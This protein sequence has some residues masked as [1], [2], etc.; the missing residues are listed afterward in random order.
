MQGQYEHIL[1][2]KNWHLSSR[3]HQCLGVCEGMLAALSHMPLLPEHYKELMSVSLVKGAQATTAIEGNTLSDS[4]INL[5]AQGEKLAPSKEYQAIEV[6][7]IL[8]AFWEILTGMMIGEGV[9]RVTPRLI[10]DLHIKVGKDLGEHFDAIPGRFREDRRIVGPYRTP[11]PQDVESLVD[12]LCDWLREEFRYK[13]GEQCYSDAIVQAIVAHIYLEWIHPFGDG[14]GRTGRLLEFYIL[15]RAGVPNI[16]LHTLSNFYN[17]TRNE[18]YRH[19]HN[20]NTTRDLTNLISYAIQ[21]FK[22]GLEATLKTVQDAQLT[23][24]WERLIYDR[25]ASYPYR[26]KLMFQRQRM[27]AL[28]FPKD[29]VLSVDEIFLLTPEIARQYAILTPRTMQRDLKVLEDLRILKK[30]DGLYQADLAQLT[31]NYPLRRN[32]GVKNESWYL[33]VR[34][35]LVPDGTRP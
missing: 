17:S 24:T 13:D 14:N 23:L 25:F 26:K 31:F 35:G 6:K 5:V 15:A 32:T 8:D 22:D 21:G 10:K 16:A 9:H 2:R 29:R 11:D 33:D 18:Y 30:S 3:A 1:F 34:D 12:Q 28:S 20:A 7:N 19:I 4:E 27:L